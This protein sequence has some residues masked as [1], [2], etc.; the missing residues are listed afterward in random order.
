MCGDVWEKPFE[1]MLGLKRWDQS[2]EAVL[3][4][5]ADVPGFSLPL[6]TIN[7]HVAVGSCDTG[8]RNSGA[9][10]Q[11]IVWVVDHKSH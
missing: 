6:A 4:N 5:P 1:W 7:R 8:R 11:L 3:R 2:V 10:T 9:P